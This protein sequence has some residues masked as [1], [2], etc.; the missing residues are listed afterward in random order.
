MFS[1]KFGYFY[2]QKMHFKG[3]ISISLLNLLSTRASHTDVNILSLTALHKRRT[4]A[5]H[6]NEIRKNFNIFSISEKIPGY[7]K[8]MK[9]LISTSA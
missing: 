6:V 5:D 3:L 7:I 9:K 1:L 2:L 4:R 8:T